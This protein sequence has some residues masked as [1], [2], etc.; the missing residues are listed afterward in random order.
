MAP[1]EAAPHHATPAP[2][3][4]PIGD[5]APRHEGPDEG[6]WASAETA[7]P[8]AS[9]EPP[10]PASAGA[11]APAERGAP[12]WGGAELV[13]LAALALIA[14]SFTAVLFLL[15]IELVAGFAISP[16]RAA[17]GVTVLPL[18]ALAGAALRGPARARA[19]AGALLCGGGAA[20]AFLPEPGSRGRSCRRC[21]PAPAWAWPCR[22]SRGSCC[23]SAT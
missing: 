3:D 11:D 6:L 9:A 19:L 8:G 22:R 17:I 18:A 12:A 7:P 4:A 2:H 21:W 15:V 16:L 10:A 20:L 14:A 23:P 1:G 13:P 5:V